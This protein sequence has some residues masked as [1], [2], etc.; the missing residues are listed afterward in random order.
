MFKIFVIGLSESILSQKQQQTLQHCELIIGAERF[1]DLC[2]SFTGQFLSISP[3]GTA[4]ASAKKA[5]K[6][7]NIAILASGDPL[8]FGIGKRVLSEFDPLQVEIQ[9][10]LSAIQQASALFKIS[11]DDATILSLHGRSHHHIPGMLLQNEKNLIFT[12]SHNSPDKIARLT[13]EY[14]ELIGDQNL[15][16]SI[17]VHVA[18]DIGLDSQQLFSGSL[19]TTSETSF[20]P[21]NVMCVIIPRRENRISQILGLT[22]KELSHSRGLI[23]KNE[24]RAVTL[25]A[26]QPKKNSILWDVG[27]GSGSISIESARL[28][29]DMT[30]YAIEHKAEGIKNI[31]AN[32]LRF[33][34]YNIIPVFGKAPEALTNLPAPDRVFVG[35]SGG[36]LPEIVSTVTKHLTTDGRLIINGVIKKT[37]DSAPAIMRKNGFQVTSCTV[38]VVRHNRQNKKTVYNPITIMTGRR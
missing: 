19:Q 6:N 36:C 8:F 37:I 4:L 7:S 20:S 21:L 22:E 34:C 23:T 15:T 38:N 5:I 16:D 31:I 18:A 1:Q 17:I 30:V 27:A 35:G 13:L 33:G 9:P 11:W 2:A 32:I 28:A 29:P 26:L 24:V 25:H 14:L 12:D 10:A 3:L